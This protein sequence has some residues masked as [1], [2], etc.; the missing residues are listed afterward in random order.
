MVLYSLK[1]KMIHYFFTS[2]SIQCNIQYWIKNNDSLIPLMGL[3]WCHISQV[4]G[5]NLKLWWV[6]K[7]PWHYYFL[8]EILI[9]MA[10][11]ERHVP[12]ASLDAN[13]KSC[14]IRRCFHC[15]DHNHRT[16]TWIYYVI[17]WFLLSQRVVDIW[18]SASMLW[19]ITTSTW[20]FYSFLWVYWKFTRSSATEIRSFETGLISDSVCCCLQFWFACGCYASADVTPG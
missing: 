16:H 3:S 11:I 19:L 13:S 9:L 6:Q 14:H 10:W 18:W 4:H 8:Y 2:T 1:F 12:W 7:F 17:L 15:T 5:K 20:T